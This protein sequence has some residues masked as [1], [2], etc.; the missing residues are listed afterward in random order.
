MVE[1]NDI[2]VKPGRA[3]LREEGRGKSQFHVMSWLICSKS[4][5]GSGNPGNIPPLVLTYIDT[6]NGVG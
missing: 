4:G 6:Y 2:K 5:S 1:W 3:P